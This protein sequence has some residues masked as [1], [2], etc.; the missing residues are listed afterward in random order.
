MTPSTLLHWGQNFKGLHTHS[1]S[2]V[3]PD[4]T[5]NVSEHLLC[6][7][8]SPDLI[9]QPTSSSYAGLAPSQAFSSFPLVTCNPFI[10]SDRPFPS[11]QPSCLLLTDTLPSASIHYSGLTLDNTS[12]RKTSLTF[13]IRPRQPHSS[14][15]T[16]LGN[17]SHVLSL[18]VLPQCKSSVCITVFRIQ[19]ALSCGKCIHF[20]N[21]SGVEAQAYNPTTWNHP[22][23]GNKRR[24][25]SKRKKKV[26]ISE[27]VVIWSDQ[28][29]SV[30]AIF[31][32]Y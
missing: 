15:C 6:T 4:Y 28:Q 8:Q 25:W 30:G 32:L 20:P 23:E 16:F 9:V 29:F 10:S 17:G 26:F 19:Q 21:R 31:K 5:Q 2:S 13:Q 12:S 18:C 14:Y 1:L 7:R 27:N 22:F 11:P 24:C 3:V